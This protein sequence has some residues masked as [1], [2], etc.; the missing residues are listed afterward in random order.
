ML[1]LSTL[2]CKNPISRKQ[3]LELLKQYKK[4]VTKDTDV[5]SITRLI[6]RYEPNIGRNKSK[7]KR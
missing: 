3:G 1:N 7:R 4:I 6:N 2:L 5:Q